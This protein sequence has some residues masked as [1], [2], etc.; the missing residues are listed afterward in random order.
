MQGNVDEN[1]PR[2]PKP[3]DIPP[4]TFLTIH[5][6]SSLSSSMIP[7]AVEIMILVV[8]FEVQV[9]DADD[10]FEEGR[11]IDSKK[12]RNSLLIEE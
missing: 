6:R 1:A 2:S 5:S 3:A 10:G 11:Q 9:L 7:K 8:A 4:R 12:R